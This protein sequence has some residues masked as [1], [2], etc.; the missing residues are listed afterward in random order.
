MRC[1]RMVEAEAL[2]T[3]SNIYIP[4]GAPLRWSLVR[5]GLEGFT[6]NRW[7]THPL[8]PLAVDPMF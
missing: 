6:E 7:A 3:Q 4:F 1:R 2:L 8:F 5:G